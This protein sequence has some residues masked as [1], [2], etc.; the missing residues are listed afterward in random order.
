MGT[1]PHIIHGFLVCI[2]QSL[3][4]H[5]A[6]KTDRSQRL[7]YIPVR[8]FIIVGASLSEQCIADLLS[9]HTSHGEEQNLSLSAVP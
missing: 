3:C 8:R 5:S 2:L 9:W 6:V 7:L 4:T 1:Q